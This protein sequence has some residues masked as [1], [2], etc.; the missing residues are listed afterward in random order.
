M[1]IDFFGL[2]KDPFRARARGGDVFVGPQQAK[3]LSGLKK[4][5]T[6]PDT[7][8]T[9]AGPVGVGKSTIVGRALDIASAA[10]HV[11][12]IGRMPLGRSEL[13]ELAVSEIGVESMPTST[14]LRV[15]AFKRQLGEKEDQGIRVQ[16]LV[17]DAMSLSVE[18]LADLESLTA[19]GEESNGANLILMGPPEL[20][21]RMQEPELARLRQR[22]RLKVTIDPFNAAEVRGY[23]TH[24]LREANGSADQLFGGPVLDAIHSVSGGLPRMINNVCAATLSAAAESGASN[25]S[26][27]LMVNVARDDF[28]VE[29]DVSSGA[30][31]QSDSAVSGG[32]AQQGSEPVARAAE[33]KTT[34]H[35][36]ELLPQSA[37]PDSQPRAGAEASARLP[38]DAPT[39]ESSAAP[40]AANVAATAAAVDAQDEFVVPDL[41]HDTMPE[42]EALSE[43]DPA[44][45]QLPEVSLPELK[46]RP[47][48]AADDHHNAAASP[49]LEAERRAH[50]EPR[51]PERLSKDTDPADTQTIKALDSALRP[52]TQL[53]EALEVPAAE[54]GSSANPQKP[55]PDPATL[56]TLSADL[57]LDAPPADAKKPDLNKLEAALAVARKGPIDVDDDGI[58][59]KSSTATTGKTN[60]SSAE[61]TG[62]PANGA[63]EPATNNTAPAAVPTPN[64]VPEITL[65]QSIHAQREAASAKIAAEQEKAAAKQR[66]REEAERDDAAI[67]AAA[68]LAAEKER[69]AGMSSIS[70]Q[71]STGQELSLAETGSLP[72]PATEAPAARAESAAPIAT[73]ATAP[74]PAAEVAN[75]P[76]AAESAS[77]DEGGED[78][79]KLERVARNLVSATT[80]EDIDEIAAETLFGEE[81]TEIAKALQQF[82]PAEEPARATELMLEPEQD[83]AAVGANGQ[84]TAAAPAVGQ[85][86]VQPAASP[87][88]NAGAAARP[89]GMPPRP[90]GKPDIDSSAMRRLAMVR[91]LNKSKSP[92]A[93]GPQPEEIV[94]STPE[95][96]PPPAGPAPE[97]IEDQFGTSMTA[98]LKALSEDSM[99]AVQIAESGTDP[100]HEPDDKKG[101]IFSRFRRS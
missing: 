75:E 58:R 57:R 99:Q 3:L 81:I 42:I 71:F 29:V 64:R 101:G 66:A 27:A 30:A 98:N 89:A 59:A 70:A 76:S 1:F 97:P 38:G 4:A 55:T 5:L 20:T 34:S 86:P 31:K 6:T 68:E 11:V 49:T 93:S 78:R 82:A 52:D 28:G 85:T 43:S 25:V 7:V 69:L 72:Q 67:A 21:D 95:V 84:A 23:V 60:D 39:A 24:R 13:L 10:S 100:E 15:A 33:P 2:S 35:A 32:A 26:P 19:E 88:S 46:D 16:V 12:R 41:I 77:S 79:Q 40:G 45:A 56:P 53:L 74:A 9:I 80:L 63:S 87:H 47:V 22:V 62:V 14:P 91:S 96:S 48:P 94:L 17:E 36:A 37:P 50:L 18:A 92:P 44:A 54:E 65:D 83:L 61:V 90:P 73:A 8:V 51:A